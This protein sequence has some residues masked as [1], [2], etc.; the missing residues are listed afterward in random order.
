MGTY[1]RHGHKSLIRGAKKPSLIPFL[2][3]QARR[4][5]YQVDRDVVEQILYNCFRRCYRRGWLFPRHLPAR[6]M[7]DVQDGNGV[8]V[9]CTRY[10][11]LNGLGG[12]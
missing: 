11:K 12:G 3:M 8:T 6:A 7:N 5:L 4:Y 10:F 1:A 9:Y 2:A